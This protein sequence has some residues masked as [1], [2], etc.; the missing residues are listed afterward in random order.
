MFEL[1]L[2][3][4]ILA[5]F[6]VLLNIAFIII[7]ILKSQKILL[8]NIKESYTETFHPEDLLD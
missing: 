8:K 6:Y 1:S 7:D 4:N 2:T 3:I 5:G